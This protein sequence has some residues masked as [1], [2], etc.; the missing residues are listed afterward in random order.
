MSPLHFVKTIRGPADRS[1]AGAYFSVELC[2]V[3]LPAE[4]LTDRIAGQVAHFTLIEI[5]VT[6]FWQCRMPS[7]YTQAVLVDSEA[8]QHSMQHLS[9]SATV[10][11]AVHLRSG[12]PLPLPAW[13]IEGSARTKGWLPFPQLENR[14]LP[15]RLIYT[16]DIFQPGEVAGTVEA[17]ETLELI[18]DLS[19]FSSLLDDTSTPTV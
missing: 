13:V 11:R 17:T 14:V 7:C 18:F 19:V 16:H 15:H 8:F 10:L 6:N 3:A 4:V 2:R 1:V 9:D 5:I 12:T